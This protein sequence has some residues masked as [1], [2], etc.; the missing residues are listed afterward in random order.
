MKLSYRFRWKL[1]KLAWKKKGFWWAMWIIVGTKLKLRKS[2][3]T[4]PRYD[5]VYYEGVEWLNKYG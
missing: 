4:P 3:F 5:D 1:F 2:K